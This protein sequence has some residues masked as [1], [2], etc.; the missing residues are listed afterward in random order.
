MVRVLNQILLGLLFA[1]SE[2][3]QD[4]AFH[5]TLGRFLLIMAT[6][7]LTFSVS[8]QRRGQSNGS[9][10]NP[11]TPSSPSD[12]NTPSGTPTPGPIASPGTA[13]SGGGNTFLGKPLESYKVKIQDLEAYK[14]IL[15]PIIES[16]KIK[17]R[18]TGQGISYVLNKKT[19]YMIPSELAKLSAEQIGAAV[20]GEQAALQ[21]FKQVWINSLIFDKMNVKD[22]AILIVHEIM[23]GLRLL[24]LDKPTIS[25]LAYQTEFAATNQPRD[26]Y[27]HNDDKAIGKPSDLSKDDYSQIRSATTQIIEAGETLTE[28]GW[29][30]ILAANG[31]IKMSPKKIISLNDL[32][33]MVESSKL[34]K[35][36]PQYGFDLGKFFGENQAILHSPEKLEGMKFTSDAKCDFDIKIENDTFSLILMENGNEA[37]YSSRWTSEIEMHLQADMLTRFHLFYIHSPKLKK[38]ETPKKGD[39]IAEI[40]L[41]FA[42]KFLLGAEIRKMTCINDDCSQYGAGIDGYFL[43]C[44]TQNTGEIAKRETIN[45]K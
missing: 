8:C 35:T 9:P 1:L 18:T 21:D 7:L 37:K 44:S 26:C 13:D 31:F 2:S 45:A 24:K 40:N 25:C 12:T 43:N 27:G 23:M 17:G 20:G 39:V 30:A 5:M 14:K 36:W 3:I 28:D 10:G 32:S 42:E 33:E 11:G 29:K 38:T 15:A 22:Q 19:W 34:M 41:K 4:E 6:I 16:E